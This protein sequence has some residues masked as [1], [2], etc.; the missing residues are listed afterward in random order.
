MEQGVDFDIIKTENLDFAA[1]AQDIA[2]YQTLIYNARTS[3]IFEGYNDYDEAVVI[4]S[5]M[6]SGDKQVLLMGYSLLPNSSSGTT[7]IDRLGFNFSSCFPFVPGNESIF[8][9]SPLA[10]NGILPDG[11][12]WQINGSCPIYYAPGSI[13]AATSGQVMATMDLPGVSVGACA[14][15]VATDDLVFGNRSTVLPFTLEQIDDGS[16]TAGKNGA[17]FSPQANLVYYLLAWLDTGLV[18]GTGDIPDAGRISVSAHPNPFNPSTTITFDL[19]R[20]AEV[21]LDNYDLQGR[22]VRRLLNE[23]P[24]VTGSHKQVWDGRDGDGR[25]T[26]SGVYFYRFT[27][28]DQ[29]R[30]GKLTL[31]K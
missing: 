29:K 25:A 20:A 3:Y 4:S 13:G 26:S 2:P 9:I 5:W 19:P 15:V 11:S 16:I 22:L 27:A 1:S 12:Q 28:G 6:D 21:S 30:V 10:G 23:S 8:Q 14:S 24:Y 7:L 31:L 18:S 17:V